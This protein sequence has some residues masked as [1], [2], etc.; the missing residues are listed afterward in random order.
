MAKGNG[1]SM[2]DKVSTLTG[3]STA[4]QLIMK[5]DFS[6]RENQRY[7]E[8]QKYLAWLAAMVEVARLPY[9]LLG[10]EH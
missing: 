5:N 10:K 3:Q 4:A 2:A 9:L 6:E 7:K 8:K 1:F